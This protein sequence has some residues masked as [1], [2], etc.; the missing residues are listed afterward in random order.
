MKRLPAFAKEKSILKPLQIFQ[1]FFRN[2]N[3]A[4]NLRIFPGRIM[5]YVICL[6]ILA[7]PM[8]F[9]QIHSFVVSNGSLFLILV[10]PHNI[11]P[12]NMDLYFIGFPPGGSDFCHAIIPVDDND[13]GIP[14]IR[15]VLIGKIIVPPCNRI[16]FYAVTGKDINLHPIVAHE[17]M[18]IPPHD[19]VAGIIK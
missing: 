10:S 18:P 17:E 4:V 6:E 8:L 11:I 1:I 9:R 14:E 5:F 12:I 13:V 15:R 3:L 19:F 2:L 7:N 16:I